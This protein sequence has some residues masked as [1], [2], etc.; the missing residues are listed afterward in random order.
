MKVLDDLLGPSDPAITGI[1][2]LV[3]VLCAGLYALWA[4][5]LTL[6]GQGRPM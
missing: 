6:A 3:L 5:A 2:V 1:Q 4:S